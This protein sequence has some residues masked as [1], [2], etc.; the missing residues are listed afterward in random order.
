LN[1][2]FEIEPIEKDISPLSPLSSVQE[3]TRQEDNTAFD[4]FW[5][6]Y[7]KRVDKGAARK[8]W[9][10]AMKGKTSPA[11]IIAATKEYAAER[12][13]QDAK[14]TKHPATWLNAESW[15]NER[16]P[17]SAITIDQDGN[18]VMETNRPFEHHRKP[19]KAKEYSD[20]I[21]NTF[22]LEGRS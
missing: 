12:R 2:P 6:S 16:P 1:E 18:R 5:Q 19:D 11:T 14:F 17:A 7:P 9:A 22:G 15:L 8:A 4:E 20:G 3:R 10:K 13:G 21:Y